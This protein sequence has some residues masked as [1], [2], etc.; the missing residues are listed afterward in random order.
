MCTLH[1][2]SLLHFLH[3]LIP[4]CSALLA[5]L[6][7]HTITSPCPLTHFLEL[8]STNIHPRIR[9]AINPLATRATN[10][11]IH[12]CTSFADC[13]HSP[14][15]H[16]NTVLYFGWFLSGDTIIVVSIYHCPDKYSRSSLRITARVLFMRAPSS[17][18]S[19]SLCPFIKSIY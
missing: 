16:N 10:W 13:C 8:L 19:H 9:T 4:T 12:P 14:A 17:L 1:Y 11:A 3:V 2:I 6:P 5:L 18:T 15:T 7:S